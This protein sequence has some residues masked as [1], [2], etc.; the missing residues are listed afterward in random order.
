LTSATMPATGRSPQHSHGPTR[1]S[2]ERQCVIF[3]DIVMVKTPAR[4]GVFRNTSA[5]PALSDSRMPGRV[6]HRQAKSDSGA[7]TAGTGTITI[8]AKYYGAIGDEISYEFVAATDGDS[9][10]RNLVITVGS[11]YSATYENLDDD[12]ITSLVDDPYIDITVSSPTDMPTA[13][14]SATALTGGSDGTAVAAD[15]VGTGSSSKGIRCF[16]GESIDCD[17]LFVAECPSGLLDDV[18]TGLEAYCTDNDKGVVVL[19]TVDDQAKADAATYVADYRDDR[20]VYTWPR[21][22]TTNW[23]STATDKETEVC[24]SAFAAALI[25]NVDPWLSPGGNGARQ[26]STDLL[27]GITGLE[28]ETASR[29]DLDTLNAAGIA[30]WLISSKLGA[31]MRRG[32][33][34]A[35]TGRTKIFSRRMTDY[36]VSAIAEAAEE[37]VERPLD[38]DLS[39]QA[40]GTYTGQFIGAVKSFLQREQDAEHIRSY[41]VDAYSEN[42]QVGIDAGQ[43]TVLIRVKQMSMAEETILKAEIGETVEIS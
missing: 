38:L 10:H 15:Y 41:S 22:K 20:I 31:M 19:C 39:N 25:V 14:G 43:W 34:T 37:I 28:D 13:A 1:E 23:W 33:T 6:M 27:S 21:V 16:Y 18:N 2:L 17:V 32:V 26:G 30:P 4:S 8:T 36:L 12:T 3:S 5:T 40:L 9:D 35:L 29:S 7:I 42:T 11:D 24:G